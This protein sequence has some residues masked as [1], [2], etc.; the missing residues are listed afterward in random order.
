MST[1]SNRALREQVQTLALARQSYAAVSAEVKRANEAFEQQHAELLSQLE[2]ARTTMSVEE[3]RLRDLTVEEFELT[4]ELKPAAGVSIRMVTEID[5][6]EADAFAWA[7]EHNM[8]LALDRKGF[9]AIAKTN[10][11]PFVK[12]RKVPQATIAKE[13]PIEEPATAESEV[14]A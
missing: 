2:E 3:R 13:L 7:K 4:G 1:S 12:V 5:Y 6:P 11:L 10:P 9:D 14:S 8:A